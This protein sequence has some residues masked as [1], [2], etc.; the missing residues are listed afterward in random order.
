MLQS[1]R[2]QRVRHDLVTEQ[3][4]TQWLRLCAS[5]AGVAGS[6]PGQGTKIPH[7][8]QCGQKRKV[9]FSCNILQ[10]SLMITKHSKGLAGQQR[11]K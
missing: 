1:M 4:N 9:S 3:Q 6:N 11:Q 10:F 8:V 5:T 7:A 2:S